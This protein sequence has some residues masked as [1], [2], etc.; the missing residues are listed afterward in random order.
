MNQTENKLMSIIDFEACKSF[1]DK[2]LSEGEKHF[3]LC[4][5]YSINIAS[6]Y[7]DCEDLQW[8]LD[9]L[10]D[11]LGGFV[12]VSDY[13]DLVINFTSDED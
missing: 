7:E 2:G 12:E 6:K 5:N 11:Y 13:N 9:E 4:P 1:V 8:D 10:S 3:I